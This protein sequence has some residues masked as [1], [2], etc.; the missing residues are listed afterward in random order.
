MSQVPEVPDTFF[1][2]E[3]TVQEFISRRGTLKPR[4]GTIK[5]RRGTLK[6]RRGFNFF[7][8]RIRQSWLSKSAKQFQNSQKS[9]KINKFCFF[10]YSRCD[11]FGGKDVIFQK[12]AVPLQPDINALDN[13]RIK[14]KNSKGLTSFA[15]PE[16]KSSK[17]GVSVEYI[18]AYHLE[19]VEFLKA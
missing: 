3:R 8:Q 5:P 4:R 2:T 6:P 9:F 1:P 17:T 15:F 12:K 16:A 18:P 13:A 10:R 7:V 11:L 19:K 14:D